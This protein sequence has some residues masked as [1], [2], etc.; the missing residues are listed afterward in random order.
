MLVL[1]P[2]PGY[3]AKLSHGVMEQKMKKTDARVQLVT[4][5]ECSQNVRCHCSVILSLR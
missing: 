3:V 4:E 5:S 1:V 2:V